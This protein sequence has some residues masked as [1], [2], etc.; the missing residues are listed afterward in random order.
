MK[1]LLGKGAAGLLSKKQGKLRLPA[2][3]KNQALSIINEKYFD[4]GP[5]LAKEKLAKETL[6]QLMMK[7]G[8]FNLAHEGNIDN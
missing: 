5:T 6:R 7:E 8:H 3:L 1:A 2:E 4:Y